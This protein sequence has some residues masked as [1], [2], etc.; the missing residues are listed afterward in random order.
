MKHV[1]F[2]EEQSYGTISRQRNYNN[3]NLNGVI[4]Y[5][6]SKGIVHTRLGA[7]MLLL[8]AAFA[9]SGLTSF[10]WNGQQI[11]TEHITDKDGNIYL[12]EDYI[13]KIEAEAASFNKMN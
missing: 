3:K 12:V 8:I 6:L 2:E 9:M 13:K 5:L 10:L 1:Y 11:D 7:N 4:N